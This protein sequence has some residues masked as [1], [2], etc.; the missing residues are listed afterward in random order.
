[1]PDFIWVVL[2]AALI[3]FGPDQSPATTAVFVCM[4]VLQIVETKIPYFASPAGAVVSFWVKIVLCYV[5]MD[6][7]GQIASPYY[8]LLLLPVM[9]SATSFGLIGTLAASAI[10]CGV[11]LQFLRLLTP[12][13]YIPPDQIPQLTL[14][15]IGLPIVGFL[16]HQLAESKR[17]EAQRYQQVATELAAANE[18]LR[19]AEDVAHRSERLAALGQLS[20]GLAHELRNPLGTM[21]ASAEMLLRNVPKDN[22]VATEMAE[23]ISSEVNRTD[24][25]ITRFLDFAR[26]LAV[27]LERADL[28]Q[29]LDRAI[30]ELERQ[31]PPLEVTIY[32]NYS[33]DIPPF[34]FDPELMQRV[35]FNLVQNAVQASPPKGSVTVKTRPRDRMAEVAVIDRG[36]GIDPKH[37]ENIFNP[38]FTTKRT[39]VGLGLAIVSKI[40]D[41]HGG[42][43]T[44]E[45]EPGNGSVFRVLLPMTGDE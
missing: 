13:Q 37:R 42:K 24:S 5:L 16:T 7:T 35:F 18:N 22:E 10:A 6:Q 15:L 21:K 38:F 39:G 26:P 23:F 29:V 44:V 32:K 2:F 25:L 14:R 33:P 12:E 27:R 45:S 30:A 8:W 1:M 28:G 20:A 41:E 36:S 4:G 19:K 31:R 40:V 17:A 43:I 9:S 11:Y 34:R 3:L